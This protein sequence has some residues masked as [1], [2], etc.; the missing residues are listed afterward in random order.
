MNNKKDRKLES[1]INT[2]EE[3]KE[4]IVIV[5]GKRDKKALENLG[6]HNT[7]PINGKPLIEIVQQIA[8]MGKTGKDIIIL[9]DFD[10]EGRRIASKLELLLKKYGV[11]PNSRLRCCVMNFGWNKIE[12]L[13]CLAKPGLR[14][15]DIHV[16]ASTYFNKVRDKG[17]DKGQRHYRKTR[18]NR[19]GLRSD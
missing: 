6:I 3:L 5:E 15:D 14:E 4:S 11:H 13:N 7:V 8:D 12:D 16:K 2:I 18:H 10:R 9:T 19:S 1:F 17:K